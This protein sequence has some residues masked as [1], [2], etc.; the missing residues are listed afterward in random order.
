MDKLMVLPL[1]PWRI[2]TVV[3][4][5]FASAALLSVQEIED[6]IKDAVRA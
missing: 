6:T 5:A 1:V 3:V 2:T 4:W